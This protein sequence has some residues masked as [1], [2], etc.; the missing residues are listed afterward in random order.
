TANQGGLNVDMNNVNA[1]GNGTGIR[2]SETSQVVNVSMEMVRANEND[3]EGIQVQATG[4]NIAIS[5]NNV[6]AMQN[7]GDNLQ[8][9]SK[10]KPLVTSFINVFLNDTNFNGSTGGSGIV[11]AQSG[12][13]GT[14]YIPGDS[15]TFTQANGNAVNG[16]ELYSTNSN[17]MN[18]TVHS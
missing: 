18:V 5:A 6:A 7:G 13:G 12:G 14:L 11:F 8:I 4:G 1:N 9:G 16:L 2:I 10:A 15:N 17:V 3:N